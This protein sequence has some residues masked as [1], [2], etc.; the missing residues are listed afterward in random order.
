MADI[1]KLKD[2]ISKIKKLMDGIEK[3]GGKMP[4]LKSAVNKLETAVNTGEDIAAAAKETSEH[5][6]AFTSN[7][8]K[9]CD[10]DER[11]IYMVK[12]R[13]Q[14]NAVNWVFS[15]SLEKSVVNNSIRNTLRRYMPELIC[16]RLD[17]CK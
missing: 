14:A 4:N 1:E 2:D 12:R 8:V 10:G 7:L 9:A 3:L 16:K 17:A 11:C 6:K 15:T 5:L 13:Y